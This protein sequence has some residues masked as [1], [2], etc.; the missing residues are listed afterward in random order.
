[1]QRRL[2]RDGNQEG[3]QRCD[4]ILWYL[5]QIQEEVDGLLG[6]RPRV[7]ALERRAE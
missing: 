5:A 1:M 6:E 2:S 3:A 4:H 7:R